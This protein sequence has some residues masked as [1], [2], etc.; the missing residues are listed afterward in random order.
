MPEISISAP[1][2]L[3]ETR[4][5]TMLV[6]L[7]DLYMGQAFLRYGECFES[8]IDVLLGMLRF[9]GLVIDVGANMGVHTV[10]LAKELARQGRSMLAFEP[11]PVIFQQLCANLALN[12]LMNVQ[13]FP[14]ACGSKPGV[15]SFTAPDY[16]REGNFG[17]VSMSAQ[18]GIFSV[19]T[20][21][22]HPLDEIVQEAQVALI[23]ID[24]EGFELEVL[25]GAKDVVARSHPVM[26]LEN[27][28]VE[29]SEAL[30]RWVMSQDYRLWWHIPT[31]YNPNNFL[32]NKENIYGM[33]GSYNML[34]L[35]RG[36][37]LT[38]EGSTEITD[39]SFHPLATPAPA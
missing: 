31:L 12:G 8:E 21:P 10:P 25:K 28:R 38:I 13:A 19:V 7:N 4:H 9:P 14:Y 24:V 11:Q 36:C 26:Y 3:T 27:D 15:V 17:G 34:C 22:C 1:Y 20:A 35:H 16:R 37:N 33:T 23:K 30:I 2:Q 6:N 18:G 39:A 32:E 5:G 29:K